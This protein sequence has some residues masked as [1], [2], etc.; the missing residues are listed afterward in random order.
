MAEKLTE[1]EKQLHL[2]LSDVKIDNDN[3]DYIKM[4]GEICGKL[5]WDLVELFSKFNFN[6]NQ[7]QT[8]KL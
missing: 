1:K 7:D 3:L 6:D 8:K 2:I 4:T 5:R